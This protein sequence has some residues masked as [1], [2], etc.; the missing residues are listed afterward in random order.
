MRRSLCC[1]RRFLDTMITFRSR[2]DYILYS[3]RPTQPRGVEATNHRTKREISSR[4]VSSS[5][6]QSGL[7]LSIR[8]TSEQVSTPGMVKLGFGKI[9]NT[10]FEHLAA[11]SGS[12]VLFLNDVLEDVY[13]GTLLI[14]RCLPL[15]KTS[16]RYTGNA[17]GK[18]TLASV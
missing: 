5:S 16:D 15:Q 2:H 1:S 11:K 10:S 13:T 4:L 9:T 8:T 7:L 17:G 18:G 14:V 6:S 3:K 12:V